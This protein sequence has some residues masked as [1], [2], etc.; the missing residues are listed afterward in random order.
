[1]SDIVERLR[2]EAKYANVAVNF[3]NADPEQYAAICTAAADEITLLRQQLASARDAALEA[4]AQAADECDIVM[5]MIAGA[6]DGASIARRTIAT[7]IRS[8]KSGREGGGV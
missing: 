7:A 6:P 3:D 5:A 4:A 2:A 1:M 8:L